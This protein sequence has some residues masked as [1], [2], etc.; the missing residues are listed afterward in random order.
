MIIAL[1]GI[2]GAGKNTLAT[3][4]CDVLADHI[5]VEVL[6][7]PR[8]G[9]R[10]ADLAAEALRGRMGDLADSVYAM[11]T[12]FALDRAEMAPQLAA[13]RGGLGKGLLLCDRYVASNA[14]YSAARLAGDATATQRVI[15]WI[16]HLEF[17]RFGLPTP[18]IQVLV[19][20]QPRTARQRAARREK[21]EPTRARDRYERDASLQERT[22][23]AYR[24]LAESHWCGQWLVTS[25]AEDIVRAV[26]AKGD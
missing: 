7:F 21:L 11:A 1:E 24:N 23:A 25:R 17:G 26:G 4:L 3:A 16:E 9:H 20:T 6:S 13:Y 12:L 8:Y 2:D 15:E 19:D 22:F 18:D 5:P 10:H 14:A